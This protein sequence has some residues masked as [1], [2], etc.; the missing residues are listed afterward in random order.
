MPSPVELARRIL[1]DA[2]YSISRPVQDSLVFEDQTILGFVRSFESVE[3]L[4]ESWHRD[5]ERFVKERAL[6]LRRDP[7]KAWNIYSVF[8]CSEQCPPFLKAQLGSIEEDFVATRK[9]AQAGIQDDADV[10]SALLPVLP[11]RGIPE[12][13]VDS[14]FD[15][16]ISR[17][18]A[19]SPGIIEG[20]VS[21][22]WTPSMLIDRLLED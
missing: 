5:E 2:G 11:L 22:A 14:P 4:V 10:V 13:K 16:F 7:S 19:V 1:A 15:R 6:S 21:D 18:R 3:A 20:L 12:V 8:L 9:I 17:A